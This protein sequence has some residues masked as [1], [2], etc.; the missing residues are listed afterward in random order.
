V[1]FWARRDENMTAVAEFEQLWEEREA[2]EKERKK[3][4]PWV[5]DVID[6]HSRRAEERE[7]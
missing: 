6:W 7:Q 5:A 4:A 2:I 3:L 1:D